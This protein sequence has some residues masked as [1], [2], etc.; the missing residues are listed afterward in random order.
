MCVCVFFLGGGYVRACV[1]VYMCMCATCSKE[2]VRRAQRRTNKSR[3]SVLA[4]SSD[5]SPLFTSPTRLYVCTSILYMYIH[6]SECTCVCARL[7]ACV[8]VGV[9]VC[10]CVCYLR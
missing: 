4:A 1:C 10:V 7:Y 6:K 3:R 9:C 5:M 8:F 2:S